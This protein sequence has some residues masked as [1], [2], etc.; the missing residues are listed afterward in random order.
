QAQQK[1]EEVNALESDIQRQEEIKTNLEA[2]RNALRQQMETFGEVRADLK[3]LDRLEKAVKQADED[4]EALTKEI[5]ILLKEN[6]WLPLERAAAL[7]SEQAQ[8][9]AQQTAAALAAIDQLSREIDGL[10]RA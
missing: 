4:A 10:D 1:E 7:K 3:E 6:W 5:Q 2:E 9:S 8:D